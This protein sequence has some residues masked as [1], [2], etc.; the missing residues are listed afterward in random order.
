MR[1]LLITFLILIPQLALAQATM[2][3]TYFDRYPPYSWKE[4]GQMK[5]ILVDI[6]TEAL[7]NRMGIN[8]EHRGYPWGRA[9]IKVEQ[10]KADAFITVPTPQRAKYTQFSEEAVL[11]V[12]FSLLV[13]KKNSK[14]E[15]IKQIKTLSDL[16]PFQQISYLGN[17][18]AKLKLDGMN[19]T[20]MSTIEQVLMLMDKNRYDFFIEAT[21][22][23][24]YYIQKMDYGEN[25][26]SIEV[27]F[28]PVKFHLCV[29]KDSP[30]IS[31]M[32]KFDETIRTMQH[33]GTLDKIYA[34][35]R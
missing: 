2:V 27:P 31:S 9:Q 18:W 26:L 32:P 4:D 13:N 1:T 23:V 6:A 17:G 29:G 34:K 30:F 16:K 7:H 22:A 12:T 33:D 28:Q 24:N 15:N 5:G 11:S 3:M 8:V 25:L 20:W 19:I 35:Y 21:H 10:N 14:L